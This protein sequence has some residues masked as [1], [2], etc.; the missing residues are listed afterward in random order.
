MTSLLTP[1]P[2]DSTHFQYDMVLEWIALL[3]DVHFAHLSLDQQCRRHLL[4]LQYKV[5]AQVSILRVLW[6]SLLM[7]CGLVQVNCYSRLSCI[8]SLEQVQSIRTSSNS[9]RWLYKLETVDIE[10]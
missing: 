7:L 10:I 6:C 4:A 5:L 2:S 9:D 3:L 1:P 8:L